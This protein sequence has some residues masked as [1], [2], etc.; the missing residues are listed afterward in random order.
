MNGDTA[1]AGLCFLLVAGFILGWLFYLKKN[2]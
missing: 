1:F 2:G